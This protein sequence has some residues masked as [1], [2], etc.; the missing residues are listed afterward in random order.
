MTAQTHLRKGIG[1]GL[2][3]GA[4]WGGVFLAPMLL[5]D[6]SALQ[7]TV[8]RYLVYG[9]LALGFLG[10]R[11]RQLPFLTKDVWWALCVLSLWGNLVYYLFLS[12]AVQWVGG[13][14]ASLV[15]GFL[16]VVLML[17]GVK[18]QHS[19]ALRHMMLPLLLSC[20]GMGFSA[21]HALHNT[22]EIMPY[23]TPQQ[24]LF[25]FLCALGAL[26]CW[27]IY[28]QLNRAYLQRFSHISSYDWS[29]LMGAVTG[30]LALL[31]GL[32][33]G[34]AENGGPYTGSESLRFW[35]VTAGVALGASIVGNRFWNQASRLLPL[36]LTG[37]VMVSETLFAM[38]YSY[39]WERRW[40]SVLEILAV[41]CLLGG[42][43]L[44]AWA[45]HQKARSLAY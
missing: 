3:A 35:A 1:N 19:P 7:V 29:L 45:Y 9:M 36:G 6:Y 43:G 21:W 15:V 11:W 16:P 24:R 25:G 5:S 33:M 34:G 2:M 4:C 12:Y 41:L 20:G 37:S 44:S 32:L 38:L 8:G 14:V 10:P 42:A 28:A 17:V 40:P 31:L 26:G 39:G 27:T 30:V 23:L 18:E 22:R 13:A